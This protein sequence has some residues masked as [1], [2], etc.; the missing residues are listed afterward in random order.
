MALPANWRVAESIKQLHRQLRPLAPNAPAVSFG[1]VADVLHTATSQ[2]YPH[3]YPGLGTRPVV[4]A[5]DFPKAGN[6]NPR[7][8]LDAIHRSRDDRILYGISEG[9]MFSSYPAGGVPAWT[10]RRYPG[11]DGHFDH[12]HLSVVGDARADITRPW[13]IAGDS[14]VHSELLLEDDMLVLARANH[15]DPTVWLCDGLRRRDV[16]NQ[17]GSL[18][19]LAQQGALSLWKN[20][21]I[22]VPAELKVFGLAVDTTATAVFTE[23]QIAA[24]AAAIVARPDNPLGDADKPAIVAAVKDAFRAGT[25]T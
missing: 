20:G 15:A 8:V 14:P 10:W 4:C 18:V 3:L 19:A 9:Q 11:A 13:R 22:W 7:T 5:G 16:T 6:L 21:Q 2:H 12:G 1:T 17:V 24:I 25:G 23:A